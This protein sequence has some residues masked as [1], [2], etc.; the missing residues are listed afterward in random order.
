M[1]QSQRL[2]LPRPIDVEQARVSPNRDRSVLFDDPSSPW[3]VRVWVGR[4][5]RRRYISRIRID[6]RPGAAPITAARLA[7]LPTVQLLH[8]ASA[9]LAATRP[10][11]H[12]NEAWYRMLATPRPRGQRTWD[13]GH[14]E[15][16]LNVYHWAV[17]TDRAG[18]GVRAVADLWGVSVTPTAYRW[19]SEARR[20][21]RA[22]TGSDAG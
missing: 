4:D 17:D 10:D 2:A 18:G 12:P 15:R 22:D 8:V 3:L 20:R 7:R 21:Q 5:R 19:L 1:T 11:T 16:V 6:A 13:D 9:Q 14:Y